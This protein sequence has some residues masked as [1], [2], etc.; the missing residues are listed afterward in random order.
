MRSPVLI[1]SLLS[2]LLLLWDRKLDVENSATN[3]FLIN[4]TNCL[5][6]ILIRFKL[7]KAE[8]LTFTI[9]LSSNLHIFKTVEVSECLGKLIIGHIPVEVW[10]K[11]IWGVIDRYFFFRYGDWETNNVTTNSGLPLAW[12][13]GSSSLWTS[14]VLKINPSFRGINPLLSIISEGLSREN[15]DSGYWTELF[16]MGLQ[17]FF[18]DSL[19]EIKKEESVWSPLRRELSD[20]HILS[21]D[22]WSNNWGHHCLP[23]EAG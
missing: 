14:T 4:F 7:N 8:T 18:G 9:W 22:A 13:N 2:L 20:A 19:G 1:L 3:H 12:F 5:L 15:T 23:V 10:D 6:C 17:H 16:E 11:A 21:I